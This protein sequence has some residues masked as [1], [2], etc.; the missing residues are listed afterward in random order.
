MINLRLLVFVY[1]SIFLFISCS[2]YEWRFPNKVDGYK[3]TKLLK[4]ESA[5][6]EINKLHGKKIRVLNAAI[7]IYAKGEKTAV[8]WVSKALTKKEALVQTEAMITK[9]RKGSPFS[10]F[11]VKKLGCLLVYHFKGLGKE[12]YLFYRKQDVFW[13]SAPLG[14][15]IKFLK[16]FAIPGCPL[17][18]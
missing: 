17:S 15:G 6:R 10:D 9:M 5:V 8:I 14:D 18:P 1:I 12:H 4:G 11:E 3:L 13:I 2:S 7:A 16:L